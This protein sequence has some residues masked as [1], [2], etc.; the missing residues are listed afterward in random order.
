MNVQTHPPSD[1]PVPMYF[2]LLRSFSNCQFRI[3]TYVSRADRRLIS[4]LSS[5]VLFSAPFPYTT[6]VNNGETLKSTF[7]RSL[8]RIEKAK[9]GKRRKSN[10]SLRT[11]QKKLAE[12]EA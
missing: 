3:C 11:S 6:R 8:T 12:C 10:S 4:M 1:R 9:G 2:I 5:I 7:S